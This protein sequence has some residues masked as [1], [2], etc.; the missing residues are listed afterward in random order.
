MS[1]QGVIAAAAVRSGEHLFRGSCKFVAGANSID[2]LPQ[3]DLPEIAFAGRSNVGKS[4]LINALTN[5]TNLAR[6]SQTPGCTKQINFFELA[7]LLGLIDLPGYGYAK[8]PKYRMRAWNSLLEAYLR[9]RP[10]LRRVLLL[11]DARHGLKDPDIN[12]MSFLSQAAVVFEIVLTKS[13]K[14][15]QEN[16]GQTIS[17]VLEQT[18]RFTTSFPRLLVTSSRKRSGIDQLRGE[19]ALVAQEH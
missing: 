13:D 14:V 8:A 9:G 19:I 11:I 7:S 3:S 4:S 6:V 5:Q 1:G 16:L 17:H 15:S 12:L 2:Q 10:T 18:D